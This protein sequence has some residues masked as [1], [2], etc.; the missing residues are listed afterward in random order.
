MKE[1]GFGKMVC[2]GSAVGKII[3]ITEEVE[4]QHINHD[5][6]IVL[7]NSDPI[8]ALYIMRAGGVLIR[9]GGVLAHSCLLAMEMGKPCITQIGNLY[10]NDGTKVALAANEGKIYEL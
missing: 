6:V 1:I 9:H 2:G 7:E 5:H 3:N 10:L 4:Y 8:N